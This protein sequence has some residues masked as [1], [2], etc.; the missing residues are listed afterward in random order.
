MLT[1]LLVHQLTPFQK[2]SDLLKLFFRDNCNETWIKLRI[3][4]KKKKLISLRKIK[5]V[6][7]K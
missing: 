1:G 3:F 2:K 7:K 4:L 5:L 6:Q